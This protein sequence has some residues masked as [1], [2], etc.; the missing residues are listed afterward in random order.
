MRRYYQ[1]P[2]VIFVLAAVCSLSPGA[3]RAAELMSIKGNKYV[4]DFSQ[5]KRHLHKIYS[6]HE[7]TL[8]CGCRY[9]GKELN[10]NSCGV[11]VPNANKRLKRLEWEHVVPA[12]RL[13]R[14]VNS[15]ANGDS[16]CK[17]RKKGRKCAAQASPLFRQMEG[18][19]YNLYPE[20]GGINQAR[21]NKPP[22]ESLAGKITKFGT[23]ET[24]IGKSG[25]VP[26]KSVRGEIARTY[27]YMSDAYDIPLTKD[28]LAMFS[29]WSAQ[30][31]VDKWECERSRKIKAVQGNRNRFV[32]DLCSKAKL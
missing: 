32:E 30:D 21:S 8:Y 12:E 20:S 19:L 24:S 3:A 27:L 4:S 11:F 18:D 28:E 23:C 6:G 29:G 31:P 2:V 15:W 25:F 16:V 13:G 9:Y 17:G 10:L 26:R 22:R 5:A 1:F 14:V 7:T